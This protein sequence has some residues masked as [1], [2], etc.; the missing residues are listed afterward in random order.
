[1]NSDTRGT[2]KFIL[3]NTSTALWED[4]DYG[5]YLRIKALVSLR[6]HWL[7]KILFSRFINL[8]GPKDLVIDTGSVVLLYFEANK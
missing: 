7:T 4:M 2:I 3:S 5:S 1:M 8:G 6:G